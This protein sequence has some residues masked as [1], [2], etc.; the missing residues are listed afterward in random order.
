M[1]NFRK[2]D[3]SFG[4]AKEACLFYRVHPA[5]LLRWARSGKIRYRVGRGG[6]NREY[7][8]SEPEEK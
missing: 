4:T 8:L 5:T 3:N 2:Y 6:K 1:K 7:E